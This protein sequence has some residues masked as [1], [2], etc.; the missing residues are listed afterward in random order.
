MIGAFRITGIADVSFNGDLTYGIG[1]NLIWALA[2]MSTGIIVACLPHLR[3]AFEK[4]LPS[5]FTRIS[6]RRQMNPRTNTKNQQSHG[7]PRLPR[8]NSISVTT[9]IEIRNDVPSPELSAPF[10][11]GHQVPWAPTFE[12]VGPLT[13]PQ[14]HTVLCR[15]GPP[16]A[17]GCCCLRL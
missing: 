12:V 9:K 3:P 1:T 4:F 6:T 5:R 7:L 11:D 10:H 16:R 8:Q 13:I 15:E 14:Q 2:Q 17:V